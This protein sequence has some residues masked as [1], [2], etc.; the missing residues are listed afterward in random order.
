MPRKY[1]HKRTRRSS[2]R[3]TSR[4]FKSSKIHKFPT[5]PFASAFKSGVKSGTPCNTVIQNISKRTGRSIS[6]IIKSL[7]K[8]NLCFSQKFNGTWICWPT[9]KFRC[10][11]SK[12]SACQTDLWQSFIDWCIMSR[13][14]KPIQLDKKTGSQKAFMRYCKHFFGQQI[15]TGSK[16]KSKRRSASRKSRKTSRRPKTTWARHRIKRTRKFRTTAWNR[17][18]FKFPSYRFRTTRRYYRRAA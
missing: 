17:S 4:S 11:S 6:S 2:K 12:I 14:V 13:S 9:F 16:R 1:K 5:S 7:T 18:S 3:R 10:P 15:S 8:A